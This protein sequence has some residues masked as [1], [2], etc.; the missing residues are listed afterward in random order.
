MRGR[1]IE[2]ILMR[3][4]ASCLAAPIVLSDPRGDLIYVNEPAEQ[5]LGLSVG[6]ADTLSV[7]A[8][9]ERLSIRSSGG[10]PLGL[11]ELPNR[12]ALLSGRAV[13][14]RLQIRGIDGRD[15]WLDATAFPLV[16]PVGENVG[17][18]SIFWEALDED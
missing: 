18:V 16:S 8:L 9:A 1:G 15:R 14:R 11:D 7:D 6:D 12:L 10:Q 3:Q 13:Q 4:L 2:L 5:L 17:I